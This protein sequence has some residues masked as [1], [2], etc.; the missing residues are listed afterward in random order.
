M[1]SKPTPID[2]G[3]CATCGGAG[4][5]HAKDCAAH[6]KTLRAAARKEAARRQGN[7]RYTVHPDILS[8]G[9]EY[10]LIKKNPD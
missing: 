4:G 7:D 3:P 10:R 2:D 9:T 6:R 1:T 8:G 5:Q